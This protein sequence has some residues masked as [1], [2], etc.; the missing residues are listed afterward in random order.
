MR[1]SNF[2]RLLLTTAALALSAC[3]WVPLHPN[4]ELVQ[5]GYAGNIQDCQH[6]GTINATTRSK[7]VMERDEAKVQTELYNLARN[8]AAAMGATNLVQHGMP[9]NGQQSFAA[10][11]CRA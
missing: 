9:E 7:V 2:R 3:T 4:A 5:I 8:N 10:Y 1:V 11:R 6:L